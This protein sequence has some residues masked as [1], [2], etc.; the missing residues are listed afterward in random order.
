MKKIVILL[1]IIINVSAFA[2]FKVTNVDGSVELETEINV[3]RP[4]KIGEVLSS[5]SVIRTGKDSWLVLEYIRNQEPIIF[6]IS[7]NN[8]GMIMDIFY[9]KKNNGKEI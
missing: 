7:P 6:I 3:W 9:F 5:T 2:Q 8:I 1:F 4:I